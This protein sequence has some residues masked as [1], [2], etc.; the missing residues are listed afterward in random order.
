MEVDV[1]RRGHGIVRACADDLGA[2][3]VGLPG[4]AACAPAFLA[5][6]RTAG[7]KLKPRKCNLVP[8]LPFT[9]NLRNRVREWLGDNLPAWSAFNILPFAHYLGFDMGPSVTDQSWIAPTKKLVERAEN[10]KTMGVVV[11]DAAR[12]Y[13]IRGVPVMMYVAQLC[14]PP[15]KLDKLE[16]R[17]VSKM[18]HLPPIFASALGLRGLANV[19]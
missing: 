4:L 19:V 8:L 18:L 12:S 14:L 3:I 16:A 15:E 1:A 17:I 11:A 10:V 7:L 13:N 5:S 2:V 9:K 6:E